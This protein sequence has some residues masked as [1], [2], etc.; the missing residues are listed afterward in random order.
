MSFF[1]PKHTHSNSSSSH[2]SNTPFIGVRAKLNI[3]ES[4]DKYEKEADAVADKV[5]Q[6]KGL[7]GSD[8]FFAPA[9]TIQRSTETEQEVQKSEETEQIQEKP[10]AES[11]T[12]LSSGGDDAQPKCNECAKNERENLL[13]QTKCPKCEEKALQKKVENTGNSDT[14]SIEQNLASSKGR[15]SKMSDSTL[16]EMNQSFGTDFSG[17]NIH[18]DSNA[19]Q[20][21]R[22]LGARAFA[23]GNDI[24][25]NSGEY[26][27]DSNEGKHLLA[28]EL[29]HTV[30]QGEN[31]SAI[32]RTTHG[33]TTPCNCHDWRIGLPPWIAGTFAH[34]QIA[35]F[36]LAA[37][38]HPQAIPRGTKTRMGTP[39]PPSGT[40]WGFADLWLNNASNVEIAEIKSTAAGDGPARAEGLHYRTRHE[41]WLARLSSGTA[42]DSQDATYTGM[43]GGP[44]PSGILD[45][46]PYTGSGISLGPFV[47]DPFKL[48]WTEGD[49]TGSVVYWCTDLLDPILMAILLGA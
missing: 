23:N 42:T 4:N 38:I 40:N 26:K 24:Y 22:D 5:V 34:G 32:Q 19:V 41:E 14:S 47:A 45:I 13:V 31:G 43:V 48:L 35:A 46:S 6:K 30:Q 44:K 11:I 49:N 15:G 16:A 37:G 21:N 1:K 27:P 18:T 20:M 12:S 39:T 33:G 28:H 36:A 9:P 8:P 2:S 17:V 7:F 3:G 25:F 10:L 29:T